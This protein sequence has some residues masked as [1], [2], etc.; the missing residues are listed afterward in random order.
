MSSQAFGG[1]RVQPVP[2]EKGVFPL[3]HFGEC[4]VEAQAYKVREPVRRQQQGCGG[5]R[6][7][8]L[9]SG[10]HVLSTQP[11]KPIQL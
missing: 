10:V 3:D 9:G 11:A 7:V 8:G 1:P 2:P 4:R 6:G 5:L